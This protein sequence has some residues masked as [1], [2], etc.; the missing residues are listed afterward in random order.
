VPAKRVETNPIWR[1]SFVVMMPPGNC[2][3]E[4]C[5]DFGL[6]GRSSRP[7]PPR[8]EYTGVGAMRYPGKSRPRPAFSAE[9]S[10][11]SDAPTADS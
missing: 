1:R 3:H 9:A 6:S 8:P 7:T 10:A 11:T 2:V 4:G 5:R